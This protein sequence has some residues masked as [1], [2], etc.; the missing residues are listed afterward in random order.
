[1]LWTSSNTDGTAKA[2]PSAK[3]RIATWALLLNSAAANSD[4]PSSPSLP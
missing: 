1:M 2:K 4:I 3:A